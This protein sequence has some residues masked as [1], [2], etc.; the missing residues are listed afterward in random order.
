M[1]DA[2]LDE[3]VTFYKPATATPRRTNS[4]K[5]EIN[6]KKGKRR[7]KTCSRI[8]TRL[9]GRTYQQPAVYAQSESVDHTAPQVL[10]KMY[11]YVVMVGTTYCAQTGSFCSL[12]SINHA[13]PPPVI[14]RIASSEQ[15]EWKSEPN[16]GCRNLTFGESGGFV[17]KTSMWKLV[18]Q[19]WMTDDDGN[20][21]GSVG[22]NLRGE[23]PNQTS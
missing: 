19:N 5:S 16:S 17:G 12:H 10:K 8:V 11:L 4:R 15:R 1:S 22:P 3:G 7:E 14:V 20:D 9:A 6:S 21:D 2:V 23:T 13:T 18:S